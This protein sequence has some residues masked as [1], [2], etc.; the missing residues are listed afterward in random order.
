MRELLARRM[1]EG[2][3]IFPVSSESVAAAFPKDPDF[4][5]QFSEIADK[6]HIPDGILELELTESIF[7]MIRD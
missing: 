7:L 1:Q 3:A 4:L 5:R 6:Y 2:K